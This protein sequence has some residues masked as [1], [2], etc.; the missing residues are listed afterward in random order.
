MGAVRRNASGPAAR[1]GAAAIASD[2]YVGRSYL[3]DFRGITANDLARSAIPY[4]A[5]HSKVSTKTVQQSSGAGH[6]AATIPDM[7][8]TAKIAAVLS[9][10]YRSGVIDRANVNRRPIRVVFDNKVECGAG[11]G[12]GQIGYNVAIVA[13]NHF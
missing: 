9:Q 6:F 13:A 7:A 4:L 3:L 2:E 10:L 8:E 1:G 11:C 5:V 12:M